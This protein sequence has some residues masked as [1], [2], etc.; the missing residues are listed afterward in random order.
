MSVA[1]GAVEWVK[2]DGSVVRIKRYALDKIA[3]QQTPPPVIP[4]RW[5][6]KRNSPEK[7]LLKGQWFGPY[8][9]THSGNII[10]EFDEIGG[11]LVGTVTAYLPA[12]TAVTVPT[13][14]ETFEAVVP[15]QP[16]DFRTGNPVPWEMIAAQHPGLNM[17]RVADT[18][19]SLSPDHTLYM[20]WVTDL[21][22]HGTAVLRQGAPNASSALK[23]LSVTSWAEF[24]EYVT[25]LEPN[26]YIFRGHE[27][28]TWRL[29][30]YFHRTGRADLRR[31]MRVDIPVL[32]RH[33]SGSK[34]S[35][36]ST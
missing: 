8:A 36:Y 34:L 32:H 23:P 27:E 12:F 31:F 33:L 29:R 10:A 3:F 26:R 6:A 1:L 24:K 25:S 2:Q 14:R 15:L 20:L 4:G 9:G 5:S 19:W 35:M 16:I 17:S 18:K 13:G 11:N 7:C 28:N 30:T 22:Y 21:E